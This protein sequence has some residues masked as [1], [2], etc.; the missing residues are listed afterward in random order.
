MQRATRHHPASGGDPEPE[1]PI[2][3]GSP[4]SVVPLGSFLRQAVLATDGTVSNLIETF[5]EPVMV[6]K[7]AEED[8]VAPA[9]EW[10]DLPAGTPLRRRTV[11]VR[12]AN[13][14]RI[15]L[16]A[17]SLLVLERL[18]PDLRRELTQTAKPIGKLI[19]EQR[20][21]SYRELLGHRS[22]AAGPRAAILGCRPEDTLVART[23]RIHFAGRP[24]IQITE[25]FFAGES[26]EAPDD[27]ESQG[28]AAR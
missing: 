7:V 22:E 1:R 17:E 10:S 25:R 9:P 20:R 13:T 3:P 8:L 2:A 15:F 27:R 5:L 26:D 6:E 21:E 18:D 19:R 24:A 11:L 28:G 23:Y 16:H 12:G 14:R 4:G